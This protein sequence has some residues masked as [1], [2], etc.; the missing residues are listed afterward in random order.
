MIVAVVDRELEGF[1]TAGLEL[2][3]LV[4]VLV[5]VAHAQSFSL[6]LVAIDVC[7]LYT[8]T[9]KP[10]N[11]LKVDAFLN[12]QCDVELFDHMGAAWAEHFKGE[13]IDKILT[14]CV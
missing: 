3:D 7:L 8:S 1:L 4:G 6:E 14:R 9:V 10:G 2:V 11:V 13:T 5:S 12:H